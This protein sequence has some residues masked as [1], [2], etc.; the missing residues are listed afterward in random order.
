MKVLLPALNGN[1]PLAFLAALGALRG[2]LHRWPDAKLSWSGITTF[3]PTLHL[4]RTV[5]RDELVNTL[6]EACRVTW[7]LEAFSLLGSD[8]KVDP[9]MFRKLLCEL[10]E[11]DDISA[12][13]SLAYLAAFGSDVIPDSSGKKLKPTALHMTAGQQQF[14]DMARQLLA[15]VTPDQMYATLFNAWSYQDPG[16]AMRWDSSGE[17]LYALEARNPSGNPVRTMRGANA[18]GILALPFFPVYAIGVRLNTRG[19]YTGDR[20]AEYLIWPLWNY[21]VGPAVIGS[22]LGSPWLEDENVPASERRRAGI[23]AIFKSERYINDHG[24]GTLRPP[25][26]ILNR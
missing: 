24:Y 15:E 22:L 6:V 19:F 3:Q 12:N 26:R 8:L 5:S 7:R 4:A 11:R 13:E 10:S 2:S 14:L 21:P 23:L 16:P 1:E 20:R 18:L 25:E 9:Y 17:R